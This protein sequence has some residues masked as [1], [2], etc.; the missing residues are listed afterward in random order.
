MWIVQG[1]HLM[2]NHPLLLLI[3]ARLRLR[4]LLLSGLS[5][6]PCCCQ[7]CLHYYQPHCCRQPLQQQ[8]LLLLPRWDPD[9]T[10]FPCWPCLQDRTPGARCPQ[11]FCCQCPR[12]CGCCRLV[13][14]TVCCCQGS[15][16]CCRASSA[17]LLLLQL[18]PCLACLAALPAACWTR[19]RLLHPLQSLL[20]AGCH[21][22]CHGL[23]KGQHQQRVVVR[24]CPQ[25]RLLD[26]TIT[27]MRRCAGQT[28]RVNTNTQHSTA[29]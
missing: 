4:L 15:L 3:A 19:A 16:Q 1:N 18:S 21:C 17:L 13:L 14:P 24:L 22:C 11:A 7:A 6:R 5:P 27:L 28:A 29:V 20:A 8:L 12:C 9:Q 10:G 26:H 23:H 25:T 2:Q